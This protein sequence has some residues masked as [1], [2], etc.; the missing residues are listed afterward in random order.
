MATGQALDPARMRVSWRAAGLLSSSS[1]GSPACPDSASFLD[2]PRIASSLPLT[3]TPREG[4]TQDQS[5]LEEERGTR[6]P[7]LPGLH[8]S[9]WTCCYSMPVSVTQSSPTL[10]GPVDWMDCSLPG[11]SAHGI[12]QE[13]ILEWVAISFSPVI[14][15]G[16]EDSRKLLFFFLKHLFLAMLDLGCCVVF[17]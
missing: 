9:P 5:A 10:C 8:R 14:K 3:A 7:L 13:R 12:L 16:N 15:T 1:D 4:C 11:S 17:L 2:L 6:A